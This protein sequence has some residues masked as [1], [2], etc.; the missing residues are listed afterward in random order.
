MGKEKSKKE[1]PKYSIE[2]GKRDLDFHLFSS[3]L[4]PFLCWGLWKFGLST[5]EFVFALLWGSFVFAVQLILKYMQ[6]IISNQNQLEKEV[7]KNQIE[8]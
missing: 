7:D 3:L 2:Q 1:P 5:I 8:E 4:L 6:F